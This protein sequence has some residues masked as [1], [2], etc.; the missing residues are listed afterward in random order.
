MISLKQKYEFGK[1]AFTNFNNPDFV[2]LAESFRAIGYSVKSTQEFSKILELAK[3][4]TSI[5]IIISVEVDYSRNRFL[6][7]DNFEGYT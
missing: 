3:K 1:S 4:S 6:I 2:K 7:D 5:P